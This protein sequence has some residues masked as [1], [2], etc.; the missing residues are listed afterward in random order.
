MVIL[1]V[2]TASSCSTLTDIGVEKIL[3][4]DVEA[5]TDAEEHTTKPDKSDAAKM[6]YMPETML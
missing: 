4:S 3:D 2:F 5:G 6:G 1:L